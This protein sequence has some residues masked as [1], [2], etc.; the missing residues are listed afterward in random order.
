VIGILLF[1]LIFS[2]IFPAYAVPFGSPEATRG[3]VVTTWDALV[4]ELADASNV[5]ETITL[6]GNLTATGTATVSVNNIT[7]DGGGF[8]VTRATT[9]T[10]GRIFEN[11]VTA[12]AS[13]TLRNLTVDGANISVSGNGGAVSMLTAGTNRLTVE[14]STFR[15]HVVTGHGG[16]IFAGTGTG[17]GGVYIVNSTF[18]NNHATGNTSDGGAIATGFGMITNS[19][20]FGNTADRAGAVNINRTG[21][22]IVNSTF[23][24]NAATGG[25]HGQILFGNNTTLVN[26]I[27]LG[28][29]GTTNEVRDWA[30]GGG[31]L[32]GTHQ[33]LSGALQSTTTIGLTAPFNWLAATPQN[34]GGDT[35]TIALLD[36]SGSPAIGAGLATA[37]GVPLL[38]QRG[39]TRK[40]PPDIGAFEF[41]PGTLQGTEITSVTINGLVAPVAGETAIDESDLTLTN[42]ATYEITDFEW[43]PLPADD[44]FS[45]GRVYRAIITL[46]ADA[47]YTFT[48]QTTVS[49]DLIDPNAPI[50][51]LTVAEPGEAENTLVYTVQFPATAG[52]GTDNHSLQ[53]TKARVAAANP[54]SL[55][56]YRRSRATSAEEYLAVGAGF[57]G[58]M[59]REQ[60]SSNYYTF[61]RHASL[62][63]PRDFTFQTTFEYTG[64]FDPARVEWWHG[65]GGNVRTTTNMPMTAQTGGTGAPW[66][67][68]NYRGTGT[69]ALFA[70]IGTP[71]F[72]HPEPGVVTVTATFNVNGGRTN[73]DFTDTAFN[74]WNPLRNAT[75]R[76]YYDGTE[77]ASRPFRIPMRDHVYSW[78]E[79]EEWIEDIQPTVTEWFDVDRNR[80]LGDGTYG[81]NGRYVA[82]E[83]LGLSSGFALTAGGTFLRYEPKNIWSAVVADSRASVDYYFNTVVPT[84]NSGTPAQIAG[85]MEDPDARMVIFYSNNHSTEFHGSDS[86]MYLF[87]EIARGQTIYSTVTS[88]VQRRQGTGT[89]ADFTERAPGAVDR[90]I[91]ICIDELLERYIFV[92]LFMENPDGREFG[93]RNANFRFDPNRDAATQ[94]LPESVASKRA[95][96]RWDPL[97]FVEFHSSRPRL[98]ID[99]CTA[100]HDPNYEADLFYTGRGLN[101]HVGMMNR[102]AHAMGSAVLGT[103]VNNSYVVPEEDIDT[104]NERFDDGAPNYSPQ[105]TMHFGS[106]AVTIESV[107][108]TARDVWSNAILSYGALYDQLENWE[109][110]WEFKLE[111]KRR[112]VTNENTDA[113]VNPFL[114]GGNRLLTPYVPRQLPLGATQFFPDFYIIPMDDSQLDKSQALDGVRWLTRSQ[115][116]VSVLNVPTEIGGTMY[117]AGAFVIDMRQGNRFIANVAL[118][119]GTDFS[120]TSRA[121]Y[122][123]HSAV[124]LPALR[125]FTSNR[126]EGAYTLNTTPF[127]YTITPAGLRRMTDDRDMERLPARIDGSGDYVILKNA[128]LDTIRLVFAALGASGQTPHPVSMITGTA[129]VGFRRGDFV[130]RFADYQAVNTGGNRF[131][132]EGTRV[133]A[134]PNDLTPLV[135]PRITINADNHEIWP[136][137]FEK[138]GMIVHGAGAQNITDNRA[139]VRLN[140]AIAGQN[141]IINYDRAISGNAITNALENGTAGFIQIGAGGL[142]TAG[143]YL[144]TGFGRQAAGGSEGVLTGTYSSSSIVSS[145]MENARYVYT[146]NC[147]II[148]TLPA[149]A[150]PLM[151]SND[152]GTSVAAFNPESSFVAGRATAAQKRALKGSYFGASGT[153]QGNPDNMPVILFAD[154]VFIKAHNEMS[155]RMMGNAILVAAA[156]INPNETVV[157]P[158]TE[159][160]LSPGSTTGST[161]VEWTFSTM[162]TAAGYAA[163]EFAIG[164]PDAPDTGWVRLT[165]NVSVTI[166]DA[167]SHVG[168][169]IHLRFAANDPSPSSSAIRSEAISSLN[170]NGFVKVDQAPLI[171]DP[172]IGR[173]VGQPPFTLSTSGG[174]GTGE[175]TFALVSGDAVTVTPEGLVTIL[176]AGEVVVNATK[177]GDDNFNPT[178][179]PN[180]SIIIGEES[181]FAG[182]VFVS[183]WAE[184]VAALADSANSGKVIGLTNNIDIPIGSAAAVVSDNDIILDGN[185]FTI[186][187][188]AGSANSIIRSTATHFTVRN[189]T[190]DGG[191]FLPAPGDGGAISITSN[192]AN[193]LTVEN[194]VFINNVAGNRG[195][196]IFTGAGALTAINSAFIDNRTAGGSSGAGGAV[197]SGNT[198]LE[199]STFFG[200]H[201]TGNGV[202]TINGTANIAS[203]TNCT[204]VGNSG[205]NPGGIWGSTSANTTIRNSIIM[206]NTGTTNPNMRDVGDGGFNLFGTTTTAVHATSERNIAFPVD[207]LAAAPADNGGNT[208]TLALTDTGTSPAIGRVTS[209]A[210]DT[211]QRGVTRK[212]AS[213]VGAFEFVEIEFSALTANGDVNT[214]TTELTIT[215][216]QAV[217]GLTAA[218]FTVTGAT[219]GT[220]SGTGPVYTLT[221]SD[222][223]VEH[224]QTVNVAVAKDGFTFAPA[225]R[226][227]VV[228]VASTQVVDRTPLEEAL[229]ATEA[230]LA[231]LDLEEVEELED[232]IPTPL[233][234]AF[235]EAIEDAFAVFDDPNATQDE[236]NEAAKALQAA[237]AAVAEYLDD[238]GGGNNNQGGGT[239]PGTPPAVYE[240]V[241]HDAYMFGNASGE[242][243]PRANTTRAEVAAILVRTMVE[244]FEYGAYP[245][246]VT[247]F[248]SFSDVSPENWF[249]WYIVWAQTEGLVQGFDNGTFRP[250]APITRQEY[251][252]MVARTGDVLD[253]GD[254]EFVDT[255]AI[256]NWA[257]DYVYTAFRKGWMVGDQNNNF[258]PNASILRAEVATATNRILGR[259]DNIF[260][261]VGIVQNLEDARSFPDVANDAWYF[262]SVLAAANDHRNRFE[263]ENLVRKY[264]LVD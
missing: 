2:T 260:F 118:Y 27:A 58:D 28:S 32:I 208:L 120:A 159:I 68:V 256:S 62:S 1:A 262:G 31:N 148:T 112:G 246:G 9:M 221:I 109:D 210:P 74:I 48:N 156:G 232:L 184:L 166:A 193:S 61:K 154:D 187:R 172:V 199:N 130:M 104:A 235:I 50:Y 91:E 33:A 173:R 55:F 147:E 178:T 261:T 64:T 127:N 41:I 110:Y 185:G 71:E 49:N 238:S 183:T 157:P 143:S 128:G 244:D 115:V 177:A 37:A 211:D 263:N 108:T 176:T 174:S 230:L 203:V 233:W 5:G 149:G 134:E 255:E 196:A 29:T 242:F 200:N 117:S 12:N 218:D 11:T 86:V 181:H 114:F 60:G 56:L 26:T 129:P 125:G 229:E 65:T 247:T 39:V 251:A 209:G 146:G 77:V 83:S 92:F 35:L 194:S 122:A 188:L 85:L 38:D 34:N 144:G 197:M 133:A 119:A 167:Q 24:G 213:D 72:Y 228:N 15:N 132:V 231:E 19:T 98:Q 220:L 207:W 219:R 99:P 253:A 45:Q 42:T 161:L 204:I 240:Y 116:A 226:D 82:L 162:P 20:F 243:R 192:A 54:S 165:D 237:V 225:N 248:S 191:D 180:L 14:N 252:A 212:A 155:W 88:D 170:I 123:R 201:A 175:V 215:F 7:V 90:D 257:L 51:T 66:Q 21:G 40:N 168:E 239:G 44:E 59:Y 142:A 223:T 163:L 89:A 214:T 69:A 140:T 30:D 131:F 95:I 258:R 63:E 186:S 153:F 93:G 249:Y 3:A 25:T 141:V 198:I 121:L 179:S 216:D 241:Y 259:V 18:M 73:A 205:G 151:I 100:P 10:A 94:A 190:F 22:R 97:S 206:G 103:Q 236:V 113:R 254:L 79:F 17:N 101:G 217:P 145:R 139:D 106:L 124:N 67:R 150:V 16:A 70:L 136:L 43:I 105:Y 4:V 250:N 84:M 195:G 47:G 169:F 46:T 52:D 23:F 57:G 224:G 202:I 107:G 245:T 234:T 222:I 78:L 160:T 164:G 53:I 36:V 96:A 87:R 8:T 76:V 81:A 182:D 80:T 102:Q 158:D 111:Y 189:I 264:I 6:G 135:R 13:F 75:T 138:M 171:V 152:Y 126:V 137:A 227:V